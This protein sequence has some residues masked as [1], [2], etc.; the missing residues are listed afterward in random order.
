V[1]FALGLV[2]ALAWPA[3]LIVIAFIIRREISRP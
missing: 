2:S 1:T 3:A